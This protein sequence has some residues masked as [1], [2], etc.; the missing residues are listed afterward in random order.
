MDPIIIIVWGLAGFVLAGRI[1]DFY[2]RR[3]Q[4]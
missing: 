3:D 2:S 4:R 1:A